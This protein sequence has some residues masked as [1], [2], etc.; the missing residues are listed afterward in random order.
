MLTSRDVRPV[1]VVR[2]RG[3]AIVPSRAVRCLYLDFGARMLY[4][5]AGMLGAIVKHP[6]SGIG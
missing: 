6:V 1:V 5:V 4:S 3:Q 2:L